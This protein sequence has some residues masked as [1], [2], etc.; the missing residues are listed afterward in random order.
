MIEQP[1]RNG[2]IDFWKY[3]AA[4]GVILV[5]IPLPGACGVIMNAVGVCGVGFFYIITGYACWGTDKE[6]MCRKILKRLKR[7]GIITV[8]TLAVY[9]SFSYFYLTHN[10]SIYL[11]KSALRHPATYF[12]MIFL[13]DFELIYGTPLWFMI[14][15][16][17]CYIIFY[18]IVRFDLKKLVYIMTIPLLVLR[19]VVDTYVNSYPVSWHLSGNLLVGALPMVCLGYVIADQKERLKEIKNW[20]LILCSILSTLAMFVTVLFYI[21]RWNIS[22][23]FK[24]LCAASIFV[25]G[26]NNPDRHICK[27]IEKC[28]RQDTLLIYLSHFLIIILLTDLIHVYHITIKNISWTLP[29]LVILNTLIFSRLVSVLINLFKRINEIKRTKKEETAPQE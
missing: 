9:F 16:L 28:A 21:G 6:L 14:A 15:L 23:P 25:Y 13:G 2:I 5:H 12:R 11:L 19:I 1:A 26:I 20:K 29:L 22:Q 24:I 17:Y 18:V 3:I 7:N 10:H 8:I 4:I 27:L